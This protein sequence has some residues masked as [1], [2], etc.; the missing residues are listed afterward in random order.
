MKLKFNRNNKL[1]IP[2][3]GVYEPKEIV[4]VKDKSV[5][6]KMLATGYF[7]EVKEKKLKTIKEGDDN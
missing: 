3:F 6:K 5:A 4:E 7:K 2:N 1:W